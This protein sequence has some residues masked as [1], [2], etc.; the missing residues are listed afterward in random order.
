MFEHTSRYYTIETVFWEEP[1]P[2]APPSIV[3]GDNRIAYKRRRFLL[4]PERFRPLAEW[5][6]QQGD[7]FDLVAARTLGDSEAFWRIADANRAMDPNEL[8]A[9]PGRRLV[10]PMPGS[11]DTGG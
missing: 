2:P 3:E 7:R 1:S 9:E 10:I 8:T 5:P 11:E 6:V 4:Q